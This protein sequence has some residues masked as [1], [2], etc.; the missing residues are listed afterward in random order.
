MTKFKKEYN[1][2]FKLVES[3]K[4]KESFETAVFRTRLS[5]KIRL[6]RVEQGISQAEFSKKAQ[7]TQRIVSDIENGNYNIGVDLLYKIFKSLG[8]ELIVD[9]EDLIT[10]KSVPMIKIYFSSEGSN[11]LENKILE[12]SPIT[13]VESL[14]FNSSQYLNN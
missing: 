13:D 1:K 7:T 10:G 11:N 8:K 2:I 9:G 4:F 3:K 5:T 12:D 14:V 6:S